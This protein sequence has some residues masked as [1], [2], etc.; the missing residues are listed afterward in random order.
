[1]VIAISVLALSAVF[2]VLP[3][4]IFPAGVGLDARSMQHLGQIPGVLLLTQVVASGAL[5][6]SGA[7]LPVSPAR[8]T[9]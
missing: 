9:P 7:R 1:V 2:F 6:T 3:A 5:S 4:E 8:P